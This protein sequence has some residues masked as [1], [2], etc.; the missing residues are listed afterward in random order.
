M[1]ARLHGNGFARARPQPRARAVLCHR[2]GTQTRRPPACG[3]ADTRGP[4]AF[5]PRAPLSVRAG[6]PP[7]SPATCLRGE[8]DRGG[9]GNSVR[10]CG[11]AQ[12]VRAP[13]RPLE[14]AQASAAML[15]PPQLQGLPGNGHPGLRLH[16]SGTL[17]PGGG[18]SESSCP[19]SRLG[20]PGGNE[21]TEI[22]RAS[23]LPKPACSH[24]SQNRVPGRDVN[25]EMQ[26]Q[27]HRK[28]VGRDRLERGLL[29]P[30]FPEGSPS[31]Q[32]RSGVTALSAAP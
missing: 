14:S 11:E 24:K 29:W 28:R 5:S 27:L 6:L 13:P 12:L 26:R 23:S 7:L 1:R 22:S 8:R 20:G 31:R 30:D 18:R 21:L 19:R 2:G 16:M 10:V 4:K 25:S 32:G 3:H 9:G 15:P 17:G